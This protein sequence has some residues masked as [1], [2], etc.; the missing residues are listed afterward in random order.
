M[1]KMYAKIFAMLALVFSLISIAGAQD[2][3]ITG[4][5]TDAKDGSGLPGVNILLV[6]TTTGTTS[7]IN[8]SYKIVAP[9][10]SKLEFRFLGF[11]SQ[12]RVADG[13]GPIEVALVEEVK[14]LKEAVVIGYGQVRKKDLTGSLTVVTS[15]DFQTG[16]NTTPEALIAGK[17]AGVSITNNGGSPGSG[18]TIRIRGGASLNASND[19]LFI[20]DGVPVES[21]GVSGSPNPLSL[22]NPN[23]IE[24]FTVLKD[25][26]ATAIYGSRASNGVIIITTKKGNVNQLRPSLSFSSQNSISQPYRFVDVL[27]GDEFR[28]MVK[29]YGTPSQKALVDTNGKTNTDWQ[30]EIYQ[31]ARTHDNNLSLSGNLK[32]KTGFN[33]PYRISGGYLFQEGILKKDRMDRFSAGVNLSPVLLNGDLKVNVNF[34]Y[35]KTANTFANRGAIG[36]A[37]TFDP[38]KPVLATDSAGKGQFGGYTEWSNRN[39]PLLLAPKNP[40]GLL[41]SRKDESDVNRILTNIQL[42][43]ALPF[44]K[45]IRANLNLGT[46]RSEGEGTIQVDSIFASDF[47]RKGVNNYYNQKKQNNLLEFYLNYNKEISSIKSRIDIVA[48]YGY[49]DFLTTSF[50]YADFRYNGDTIPNSKPVFPLD[51][52]QNRLISYYGRLN[53]VFKEKF[54]LTGTLRTDGSSR[55]NKDVRWGLFPSIAGAYTLSEESFIKKIKA[56]N[57]IKVRVG[58]GLTG[59]QD[60]GNNYAYLPT[61]QL[62]SPTAQY[63]FGN[64]FFYGYRPSAYDPR[65]KWESTITTNAALDFS[66]FSDRVSGSVDFY[67]KKTDNLLNTI[68]TPAG[69]NFSDQVLTNVGNIENRGVEININ[70]IPIKTEKYSWSFGFNVTMNRNKVTKLTAVKDTSYPGIYTGGIEGGVGSTIQIHSVGNP[71]NSF[72]VYRQ[73]YENGKPVEGQFEDLNKDG[74]INEDDQYLYKQPAPLTFFGVS[75]Q[76]QYKKLT[77]GMVLRGSIGNY[78]YNNIYSDKGNRNYA[79]LQ[80]GYV[81]NISANYNETDFLGKPVGGASTD[82]V[83]LSDYYVQNASFLRFDNLFFSYNFGEIAKNFSLAANFNVQ[84]AFVISKYKGV[85][86]EIFGGIDNNFYPRPRVFSLGITANFMP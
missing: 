76:F 83:R 26:S 1:K 58:Y 72:L 59:Q 3:E 67:L 24:S 46:D 18:S 27:S 12:V 65:I 17:V 80:N 70:T 53:Y 7:D 78:V 56:I 29:K 50:N 55:F 5:V 21:G 22:I 79:F 4:K 11:A 35:A 84:N 63:Q 10:G 47:L 23:D 62:T 2:L 15:K 86:P 45:D 75:T 60:I 20:I 74:R 8:G 38:T 19:P 61:Y 13:S 36:S 34:K 73:V 81:S 40:V 37:V 41:N 33:L 32:I 71:T 69:A 39:G 57:L 44:F 42:D 77:V 28:Q 43:Y 16:V 82:Q 31:M 9:K 48:G 52:P 66:L 25:A 6:G 51:K 30:K 85:D 68:P 64:N 14:N 54:L 49:Q